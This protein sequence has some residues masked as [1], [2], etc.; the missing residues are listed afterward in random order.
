MNRDTEG[1]DRSREPENLLIA[2]RH[3]GRRATR[4]RRM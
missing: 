2:A 1:V 4:H 3:I